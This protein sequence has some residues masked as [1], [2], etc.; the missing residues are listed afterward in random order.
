VNDLHASAVYAKVEFEILIGDDGCRDQYKE[1]FSQLAKLDEVRVVEMKKN[2]GRSV[3]RNQLAIQ[4]AYEWLLFIDAD[5]EIPGKSFIGNY[6][7][8]TG[9]ETSCVCGG[10]TYKSQE[11]L[12]PE[13][14]LHWKYGKSREVKTAKK[15]NKQPW[16]GFQS[17]NFLIRKR[18]FE[19]LTFNE[20]ISGY[21]HEDSLFGLELKNRNIRIL[22]IDN[23]ALHIGLEDSV[24]FLEKAK[25]G[26]RNLLK[27]HLLQPEIAACHIRL[28]RSYLFFRTL[29]MRRIFAF[30]FRVLD[31]K[32][33]KSLYFKPVCLYLFDFYRLAYMMALH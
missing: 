32:I 5:T 19:S 12:K 16:S 25:E 27:V 29:G 6:L 21:G 24:R 8:F 3:I 30:L 10:R 31:N 15:R 11:P 4:A 9:N 20:K 28:L 2:S 14:Y 17:N 33:E 26:V 18:V 23:P 22:H 13:L 7:S 1:I